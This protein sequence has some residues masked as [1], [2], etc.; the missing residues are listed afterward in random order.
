MLL[1]PPAILLLWCV[2]VEDSCHNTR[3]T[4]I[5]SEYSTQPRTGRLTAQT[6]KTLIEIFDFVD[7][8]VA[9]VGHQVGNLLRLFPLYRSQNGQA[10]VASA[11]RHLLLN[12][13][14]A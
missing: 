10:Y 2:S 14:V 8:Y 1:L 3:Y 6:V 11:I 9:D 12:V 7:I 13:M 4:R 5:S